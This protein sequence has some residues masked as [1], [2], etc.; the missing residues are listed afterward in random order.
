MNNIENINQEIKNAKDVLF[1]KYPDILKGLDLSYQKEIDNALKDRWSANNLIKQ[2][3]NFELE[4]QEQQKIIGT[5]LSILVAEKAFETD[6]EKGAEIWELLSNIPDILKE[7]I[8]KTIEKIKE[9]IKEI[10]ANIDNVIKGKNTATV[11]VEIKWNQ[12][13]IFER[14]ILVDAVSNIES[15]IERYMD[16]EKE[17]NEILNKINHHNEEVND[18][19]K[20]KQD[21]INNRRR[22]WDRN[23][24]IN[25]DGNHMSALSY[26]AMIN[27]YNENINMCNDQL[28]F[29]RN[30]Y[31][32]AENSLLELG[33]RD[34][35]RYINYLWDIKKEV[36]ENW[37]PIYWINFKSYDEF[38]SWLE[39]ADFETTINIITV[40]QSIFE[41]NHYNQDM[42]N[43]QKNFLKWVRSS[44]NAAWD[45]TTDEEDMRATLEWKNQ[46]QYICKNFAILW[47]RI[48]ERLWYQTSVDLCYVWVDHSYIMSQDPNTKM[49]FISTSVNGDWEVFQWRTPEE[50]RF[51]YIVDLAKRNW[52]FNWFNWARI[53][54]DGRLIWITYTQLEESV[55]NFFR[56]G[57]LPGETRNQNFWNWKTF[58][59]KADIVW[60]ITL[61][62]FKFGAGWP[63]L[64]GRVG[65]TEFST[66][67]SHWVNLLAWG[68][69]NRDKLIVWPN[70]RFSIWDLKIKGKAS[71]NADMTMPIFSTHKYL[72]SDL[73]EN[74]FEEKAIGK[75]INYW[76]GAPHI[77]SNA[78]IWLSSSK[79]IWK[80]WEIWANAGIT[81]EVTTPSQFQNFGIQT[82][83]YYADI[84]WGGKFSEDLSLEWAAKY[85]KYF[86]IDKAT[87]GIESQYKVDNT[88]KLIWLVN[89]EIER[90]TR[91]DQSFTDYWITAKIIL[92]N[93]QNNWWISMWYDKNKTPLGSSNNVWVSFTKKF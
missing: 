91:N 19:S 25:T 16:R 12:Y 5:Y 7:F 53:D 43:I 75:R 76:P 90:Q 2:I 38:I 49:F 35:F 79:P 65:L 63:K 6:S 62:Q 30:E 14:K 69:A 64:H 9:I 11:W 42:L 22:D 48:L 40:L 80:T 67:N 39:W 32:S 92:E 59:F 46:N 3:N 73:L 1:E 71:L 68:T 17:L 86:N 28:R 87:V 93:M 34:I 18:R 52:I 56:G 44:F 26:Q 41:N 23:T 58:D 8:E 13:Q 15:N 84:Y 21:F 24:Y 61:N 54:N 83:W 85:E 55:S 89:Y 37:D 72:G 51:N 31:K 47:A 57:M 20:Q 88:Y 70:S 50:A 66:N 4:E 81:T 33:G 77:R 27:Q 74:Q 78:V 36:N 60:W 82:A 29:R 10:R 45:S